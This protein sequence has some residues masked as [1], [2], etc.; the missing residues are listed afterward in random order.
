M[1]HRLLYNLP[2]SEHPI[3]RIQKNILG[4]VEQFKSNKIHMFWDC[5]KSWR[6]KLQESYKSHRSPVINPMF[7]KAVNAAKE[8]Y[9][10]LGIP[11]Y[12][13]EGIEADDLI[14][15]FCCLMSDENK[16]IISSDGD[17]HQIPY[18]FKRVS[19]Y[20][21]MKKLSYKN[22][23]LYSPVDYKCFVGDDSDNLGGV[24]GIG[25]VTFNKMLND[26]SLL[27]ESINNNES[28]WGFRKV[29][30]LMLCP[31]LEENIKY[32]FKTIVGAKINDL[33]TIKQLFYNKYRVD[34]SDFGRYFKPF[35]NGGE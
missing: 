5:S 29:I 16:V 24:K 11:Q 1:V 18:L 22:E 19:V 34:N 12:S 35:I 20:D 25:K 26:K 31:Y 21:P 13:K 33:K 30:D 8:I 28:Y 15:A 7:E 23:I 6:V 27:L 14:F 9:S 2:P 10:N 32:V 17:M 4:Y 3:K